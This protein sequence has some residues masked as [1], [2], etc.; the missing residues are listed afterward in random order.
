MSQAAAQG[1]ALTDR[2]M[3]DVADDAGEQLSQRAGIDRP[4]EAGVAHRG[5]DDRAGRPARS[6]RRVPQRH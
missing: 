4:M 5:A 3:G 2:V 1:A 6:D